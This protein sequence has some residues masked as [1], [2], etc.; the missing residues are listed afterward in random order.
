MVLTSN[1][2]TI[3]R[4]EFIND[5]KSMLNGLHDKS[6]KKRMEG[7]LKINKYHIDALFSLELQSEEHLS[8]INCVYD[9]CLKFENDYRI[10]V[11]NRLP[12]DLVRDF[13]ESNNILTNMLKP[14]INKT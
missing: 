3:T 8:Y 12:H 2:R 5:M 14:I 7:M 1:K 11:F 9:K 13:I 4:Q 10:G 6:Q